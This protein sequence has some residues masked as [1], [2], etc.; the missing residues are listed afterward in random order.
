MSEPKPHSHAHASVLRFDAVDPEARLRLPVGRYTT[1]AMSTSL[2]LALALMAVVYGSAYPFRG[3]DAGA[4]AWRYLTA[5]DR[6][7]VFIAFFSFWSVAVIVLK[8]LK[9]RAQRM[10]LRVRFAPDDPAWHISRATAMQVVS[11]IE[12][13]V[14]GVD[15]FM[16]LHRVTGALR[17]VRNVGRVG[18]L[19][20]MMS[21][22]AEDDE[23][24]VD[25][26]YVPVR[27]FIW[28]IPVLGFIGT[29]LGLTEAIGQFGGVLS[30]KDADL[31]ALTRQLTQVIGGLDTA[32]V[33]TGEGL[34]MALIIH[35]ALTLA[36]RAD[37][38]LLDECREACARHVTGRVRVAEGAA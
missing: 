13:A 4:V 24:Q 12:G 18:D 35:L 36:R 32:F 6:I 5:F 16:Y 37:D 8:L 30:Q 33:T 9:V 2:L 7:P 25:G 3:S 29:V 14:E 28:A 22:R 31:Q 15:R 38:L 23:L 26:G 17:S 11:A 10:A 1:P 27:A 34:V 21:S 19:E 20:D